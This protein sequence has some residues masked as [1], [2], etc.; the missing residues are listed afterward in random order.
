M[1][2]SA[3]TAFL[4]CTTNIFIDDTDHIDLDMDSD[5]DSVGG[6]GATQRSSSVAPKKRHKLEQ[7]SPDY[8]S[9]RKEQ[10]AK[11]NT[12]YR[13]ADCDTKAKQ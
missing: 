11:S 9:K 8:T 7:R 13:C 10:N 6:S 1:E 12:R 2:K 4:V 3:K 5:G